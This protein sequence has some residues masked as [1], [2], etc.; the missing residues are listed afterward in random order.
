MHNAGYSQFMMMNTIDNLITTYKCTYIWEYFPWKHLTHLIQWQEC[1]ILWKDHWTKAQFQFCH[2]QP[3][4]SCETLNPPGVCFLICKRRA[5]TLD[6]WAPDQ[7][8]QQDHL[9]S[10]ESVQMSRI[11]L[12][13][14]IRISKCEPRNPQFK[15]SLPDASDDQPALGNGTLENW[16]HLVFL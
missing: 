15:K 11:Y 1:R 9:G 10:F 16:P 12:E 7:A 14:L 3:L 8:N 6:Q 2:H 5:V 13:P 4:G